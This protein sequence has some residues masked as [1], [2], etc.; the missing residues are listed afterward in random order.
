MCLGD[1]ERSLFFF[2][3]QSADLGF[4]AKAGIYGALPPLEGLVYGSK[5]LEF[6]GS[7]G[8]INPLCD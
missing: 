7:G 1:R 5:V 4:L 3:M 6:Y 8:Y 2:I